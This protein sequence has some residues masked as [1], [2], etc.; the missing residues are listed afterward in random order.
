MKNNYKKLLKKWANELFPINRSLT[1][2]GNRETI[3]Y[4]KENINS[5][6]ILKKVKSGKQVF[7]W[8][9]PKEW[10]LKS[11]ILKD[12]YGNIICDYQ[13]NNLEV[14][15][16]SSPIKKILSYDQL[17]PHLYT[18]RDVPDAIPYVTSYY[19]K[20]WGFCLSHKQFLKL[21][22]KIKYEV[23]IKSKIF[24]GNMN[25]SELI[26]P[27]KS[28][29]EII[30]SSY[31]C[32]PS[33]ANNEL[34]GIL[35]ICLLSKILKKHKYTIK[36]ILIP[37]TIGAIHYI[38]KNLYKLKKN[39]VAGFNLSCV[40][41]NAPFTLI[42][43]K[44]ENTYADVIINRI[45][46]KYKNFKKISF[47]KRG[48][49]ERQFG[50]QNLNLPFV[51][52]TRKKFGEYKE[53]HTSKDNLKILNYN[54]IIETCDFI[55]KALKEIDKNSIFEKQTIGEP[56]LSKYDLI[57]SKSTMKNMLDKKRHV[58][59]NIAAFADRNHDVISL[60]KKINT[61]QQETYKNINILKKYGI[62]K[63]YI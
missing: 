36:L 37:E 2:Q 27:G 23:N 39:L 61:N 46:K 41:I 25:Y 8:K 32:H 56:Y 26:I 12:E 54:T 34:S 21:N 38:N 45:G 24:N 3:K 42:S 55:K 53:Y 60:S 57:S 44:N 35:A 1:G 63:E 33:M 40:G 10:N 13:R 30:I 5:K 11:A 17:K 59:S 28:K 51:T 52:F 22:K 43:S 50:C 6:F 62:L 7:D 49:N 31:I 4:I 20:N 58:I 47:L 29:K 48:S 14:L 9:I 16:Y 15:G 19:K 18:L